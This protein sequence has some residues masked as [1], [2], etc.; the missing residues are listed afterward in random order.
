MFS[1][2]V[3]VGRRW[4]TPA[5]GSVDL[6]RS[7]RQTV[8][9]QSFTPRE[10]MNKRRRLAGSRW[11]G[12]CR[13]P[14]LVDEDRMARVCCHCQQTT[15]AHASVSS[16]ANPPRAPRPDPRPSFVQ[17]H[18][19]VTCG[20]AFSAELDRSSSAGNACTAWC[21]Y[22][23]I[24]TALPT[25]AHYAVHAFPAKLDWSSSAENACTAW[26]AYGCI[27]TTV[28]TNA[29]HAVHAFPADLNRFSSI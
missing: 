14:V 7:V 4:R 2:H 20:H 18:S 26:C 21:A 13:Q 1:L 28:P 15:A 11:G 10:M 6:M 24:S 25:N 27:A 12:G 19:P 16:T 3:M 5:M 9:E 29:H 8:R 17:L 23:C 22:G